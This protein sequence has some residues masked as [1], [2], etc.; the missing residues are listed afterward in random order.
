MIRPDLKVVKSLATVERQHTNILEWLEEWRKHEL[1][2]LPN[3]TQ[4]VALAQGRCQ[5]LGELIKLIKESPEY[6]AKS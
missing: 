1:E 5:I 4:N 2:Q 6:A 3:V